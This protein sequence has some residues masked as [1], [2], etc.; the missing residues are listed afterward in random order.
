VRLRAVGIPSVHG[1]EE[2]K[3]YLGGFFILSNHGRCYRDGREE[4]AFSNG[5]LDF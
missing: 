4:K 1:G 3:G 5:R 2:V